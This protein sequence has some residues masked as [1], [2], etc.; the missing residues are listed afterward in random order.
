MNSNINIKINGLSNNISLKVIDSFKDLIKRYSFLDFRRF[1]NIII[2]SNFQRDVNT[3]TSASKR[4]LKAKYRQNDNTY[5]VILTIPKNNDF[6]LYLVIRADFI[7]NI[8]ENQNSVK[9]KNAL[10][11]LHH[12]FAHIHDN[13]KKID[14]FKEFMKHSS[15]RGVSSIIYPLAQSSWSEYIANFISSQS[16]KDTDYPKLVAKRLINEIKQYQLDIKT[17]L[18]VYKI[19]NS[20]D[21]LVEDSLTKIESLVRTASYLLGYLNGM[22]ITLQELDDQIDYELETSYFKDFWEILKYELASIHQVY[23]H[24]FINLNIYK[25]LSSYIEIF[26]SQMGLVLDEDEKGKLKIHIM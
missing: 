16:A 17:Y 5:A 9:Y 18:E 23:P 4:V 8:I 15:Y 7:K 22:K 24:G 25:N 1:S 20:R 3:L 12:E 26:H 19:N 11:V 6:E 13:N 10:H 2:T 14:V 21:D